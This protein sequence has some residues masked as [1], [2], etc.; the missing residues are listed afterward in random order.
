MAARVYNGLAA[1]VEAP[2]ADGHELRDLRAVIEKLAGRS[3]LW[4]TEGMWRN[5]GGRVVSAEPGRVVMEAE[6]S[7]EAH[8]F[9]TRNGPIV[10]G[11]ALAA[12]ADC[13]LASAAATLAS[14]GEVPTTSSLSVDFYRPG[15]PGRLVA[16]AEARHRTSRL[17]YCHCAIEQ[18]D[19]TVVAEGRAVIYFVKVEAAGENPG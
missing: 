13:A 1:Q 14:A 5:L 4:P 8:G 19:G 3:D 2:L 11:G 12:F 10:H 16:R 18:D 6:L 17:A 7:V 9:P 15:R